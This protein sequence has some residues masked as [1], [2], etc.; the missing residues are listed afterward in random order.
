VNWRQL[1]DGPL[2]ELVRA[3]HLDE[4]RAIVDDVTN[5]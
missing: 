5:V 2:P 1:L 3:G 4:A